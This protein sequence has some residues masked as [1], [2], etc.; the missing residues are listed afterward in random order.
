M[1]VDPTTMSTD[2]VLA[3]NTRLWRIC[4]TYL[5]MLADRVGEIS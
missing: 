1:E 2:K 3:E 4:R 5:E